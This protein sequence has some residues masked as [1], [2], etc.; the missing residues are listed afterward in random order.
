MGSAILDKHM[1]TR[2]VGRLVV[3]PKRSIGQYSP[4]YAR[5]SDATKQVV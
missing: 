2:I 5:A 1:S 3:K 4:R